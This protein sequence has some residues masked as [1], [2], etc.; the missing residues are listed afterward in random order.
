MAGSRRKLCTDYN[1]NWTQ[2]DFKV[3]GIIFST[4][5]S[6][7]L[8]KNYE[9]LDIK[10]KR[11][12][13]M[14]RRRYLT[15][16][17]K[18]TIIKALALSKLTY[19]L[20]N[21]PRPP[22]HLLEKIS[23]E[24]FK[25]IWNGNRDKIKRK[26]MVKKIEEGGV[27]MTDLKYFEKAL[28][29]TWI[30]R[31]LMPRNAWK[32]LAP[33]HVNFQSVIDTGGYIHSTLIETTSNIFWKQ[34]YQ[35]WNQFICKTSEPKDV[36]DV[37]T[38]PLW[39][40][41]KLLEKTF[42]VEKWHESGIKWIKNIINDNGE[43]LSFQDIQLKFKLSGHFL[44]YA[45]LLHIIPK[46]WKRIIDTALKPL[47]LDTPGNNWKE[48]ILSQHKPC[49]YFY[50]VLAANDI[51]PSAQAKWEEKITNG[52]LQ[53][54]QYYNIPKRST[55]DVKM[56][57]FQYKILHRIIPTN[58]ILH[59]MKLKNDN[60][61]TFCQQ[62]V[63]TIEHLFI[64]CQFSVEFWEKVHEFLTEKNI[65]PPN[66]PFSLQEIMFGC[67]GKSELINKLII[68]AKKHVYFRKCKGLRPNFDDRR[69]YVKRIKETEFY[70]ACMN[71]QKEKFHGNW[72]R[73][74]TI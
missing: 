20:I 36:K 64:R 55:S 40:N 65:R 12:L 39:N 14:W 67:T 42:F 4:N 51:Q 17:G 35:N 30:K 68:A 31:M 70:L 69:N 72:N 52:K 37:L 63:E 74:L 54:K 44:T 49:R 15:I 41:P 48:I 38:Q 10:I 19:F 45:K 61:C 46:Q 9:G 3:L 58:Y 71:M 59:K 8:K 60:L 34:L 43:T 57:N 2:G 25:F 24:C 33:K 7:V 18:I 21:L 32:N 1:L 26:V 11:T 62:Q 29:L 50:N 56:L 6:E 73:L 53:W 28:K 47:S 13:S 16:F 22:D 66:T 27:E 5:L 23:Q